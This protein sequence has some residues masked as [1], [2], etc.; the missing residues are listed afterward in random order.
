MPGQTEHIVDFDKLSA[1]PRIAIVGGERIDVSMIPT[2]QTLE[3]ARFYDS[4]QDGQMGSEEALTQIV[5]ILGKICSKN[6]PKVTA[7][8]LLDNLPFTALRKFVLFIIE[9][10]SEEGELETDEKGNPEAAKPG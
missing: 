3:I 6:N 8:F 10:L 1:E 2:R 9:P 7:D 5:G 4:A